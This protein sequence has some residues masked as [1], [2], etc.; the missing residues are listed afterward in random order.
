MAGWLG[1][2]G[3]N[4]IAGLKTARRT[5]KKNERDDTGAGVWGA[6]DFLGGTP[7]S[8]DPSPK[9]C[10]V[11][12]RTI[13]P[14]A[15]GT[16]IEWVRNRQ[17]AFVN[18]G[19]KPQKRWLNGF[20]VGRTTNYRLA[21]LRGRR[22]PVQKHPPS[23]SFSDGFSA[24]RPAANRPTRTDLTLMQGNRR[25]PY[26]LGLHL[27]L[28]SGLGGGLRGKRVMDSGTRG[29]PNRSVGDMEANLSSFSF[30]LVPPPPPRF[31]YASP[32]NPHPSLPLYTL[33]PSSPIPSY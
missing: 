7:A 26:Q 3:A 5:G 10:Y 17:A 18:R 13:G 31:L 19:E 1:R 15:W 11:A 9:T 21:L 29:H 27:L 8:I 14:S 25:I 2:P 23:N 33:P 4:P 30:L 22:R 28:C 24:P 32:C 16:K 12:R 20:C 6:D